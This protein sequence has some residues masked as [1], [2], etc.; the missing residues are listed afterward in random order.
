M[1]VPTSVF[2][3]LAKVADGLR[4][5]II[6]LIFVISLNSRYD[7]RVGLQLEKV[8]RPW[9]VAVLRRLDSFNLV[10]WVTVSIRDW[11]DM[12]ADCK[13]TILIGTGTPSQWQHAQPSGPRKRCD[14][15]AQAFNAAPC[16]SD[17]VSQLPRLIAANDI[18]FRL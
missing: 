4:I 6:S 10:C 7:S 12:T 16:Q 11:S 15:L 14:G 5:L 8:L 13:K 17:R 3:L 2:A 1:H 18:R 9:L